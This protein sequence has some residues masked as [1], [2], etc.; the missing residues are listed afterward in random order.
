M[1]VTEQSQALHHIIEALR[2]AA[3]INARCRQWLN[4]D[5]I[6]ALEEG[7]AVEDYICDSL[8]LHEEMGKI[9][10]ELESYLERWPDAAWS[11]R[12]DLFC[13]HWPQYPAS[14]LPQ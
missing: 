12:L 7:Y 11:A 4:I 1:A 13:R 10:K 6:N 5:P 8:Q 9:I 3:P 14:S 2:R